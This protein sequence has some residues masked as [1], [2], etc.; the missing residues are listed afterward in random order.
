MVTLSPELLQLPAAGQLPAIPCSC[1]PEGNGKIEET[2]ENPLG[3]HSA[4]P[5]SFTQQFLHKTSIP[6]CQHDP[7]KLCRVGKE[8]P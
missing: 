1:L 3:G 6:S 2:G 4:E 5:S 8:G 7:P